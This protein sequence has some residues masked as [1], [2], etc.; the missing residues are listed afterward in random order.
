MQRFRKIHNRYKNTVGIPSIS[1]AR[2]LKNQMK[3]AG[4][5][6]IRITKEESKRGTLYYVSGIRS[7]K[8]Q[9]WR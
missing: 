6:D 8:K 4:Y 5:T 1:E 2:D 3:A 9:R 7:K